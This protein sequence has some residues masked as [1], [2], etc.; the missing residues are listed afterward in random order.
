MKNT[1]LKLIR[2]EVTENFYVEVIEKGET[3]EFWIGNSMFGI[4]ELMWEC[5]SKNCQPQDYEHFIRM[6]FS[7]HMYSYNKNRRKENE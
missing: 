6:N 2:F 5:F 1:E 4:K 7:A 3:V